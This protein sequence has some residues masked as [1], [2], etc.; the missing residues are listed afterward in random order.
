MG[1]QMA[2]CLS[3]LSALPR[4]QMGAGNFDIFVHSS[5]IAQYLF[6]ALRTQLGE[7]LMF[8]TQL[9]QPRVVRNFGRLEPLKWN[10]IKPFLV[11]FINSGVNSELVIWERCPGC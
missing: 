7:L 8:P 1:P 6:T 2:A 5:L 9:F 4:G 3:A 11:C 10:H